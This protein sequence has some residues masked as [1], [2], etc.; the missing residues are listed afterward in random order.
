MKRLILIGLVSALLVGCNSKEEA[1]TVTSDVSKEVPASAGQTPDLS[2]AG[3]VSGRV[4]FEGAVP[5]MRDL[6]VKGNPECSVHH[7]GGTIAQEELIVKDGNLKNAFVYVKSGLEPYAFPTPTE[8]VT[9]DNRLCMY[10]PHVTG[11]Q[12]N[13]PINVLNSDATLH[14]VHAMAQKNKGWN[15]GLPFQGLKQVKR[16]AEAEVMVKFKCDVHPWMSGYLGVLP[17]PYFKVTGEDGTFEL[18]DLPPGTYEVEVWHEKLGT[19]SQSITIGPREA[20][21]SDFVFKV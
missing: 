16:F 13:Q 2:Q 17:H 12:V 20:K 10:V 9:L 14:N 4:R 8:P 5:E 19:Q 11:A 15:L 1:P 3:S 6:S 18:K 7:A 21:T